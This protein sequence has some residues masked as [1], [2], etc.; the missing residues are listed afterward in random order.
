MVS[1][2]TAF[3][4]IDEYQVPILRKTI[5][6]SW[7]W[8]YTLKNLWENQEFTFTEIAQYLGVSEET[9]ECQVG[10]LKLPLLRSIPSK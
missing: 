8:E 2:K 1:S 5:K 10:Y 3:N 9:L 6:Y 4:R 7:T